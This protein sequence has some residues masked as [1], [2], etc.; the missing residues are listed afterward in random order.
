LTFDLLQES[1]RGLKSTAGPTSSLRITRINAPCRRSAAHEISGGVEYQATNSHEAKLGKN[2]STSRV[3]RN[4]SLPS[5]YQGASARGDAACARYH[6]RQ[7]FRAGGPQD[8]ADI[9]NH[10]ATHD[11]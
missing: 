6:P 8:A 7:D 3:F 9:R 10:A 1:V 11:R 4:K 5:A 2:A